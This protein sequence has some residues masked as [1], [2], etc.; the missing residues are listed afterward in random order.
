MPLRD[1]QHDFDFN[2]GTWNTQVT[3]LLHPLSQ[4]LGSAQYQGISVV[5]TLWDGRAN[6][7]V[8]EADGPAGHIEGLGLRLYNP[9]SHQWSLNWASSADGEFQPPMIGQFVE[10]HGDFFDQEV[11]AGKSILSKNAFYGVSTNCARFEQAFSVDGGRSWEIN[12]AMTFTR[13]PAD[14]PPKMSA[15]SHRAAD[16]HAG[17]HDF[18]FAFGTWHT[19]ILRLKDPLSGSTVWLAY[20]GTHTI[21]KL[22]NGRA[23]LGELKVEGAA[24]PMEA[25][26]P[27]LY[28]P[29]T[30]LWSISYANPRDGT[31][32]RPVIGQFNDG[33]GEF[34]GQDT[35]NGRAVLVREIYTPIDAKTRRLEIAYSEDGGKNWE[36]NWKMT[37]TLVGSQK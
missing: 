26:S 10:G 28:N 16:E 3:R 1:G 12:W 13:T 2:L 20:E 17:Q 9:G 4:G 22:W 23:N 5:S 35:Y 15:V 18:D 37:D 30:H 29:T 8:L 7:L 32:S 36:T 19:R 27:R 14:A 31:L 25:M 24:G 6:V 21:R 34:F 33:R 11:F